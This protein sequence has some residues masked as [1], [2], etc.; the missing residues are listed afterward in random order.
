MNIHE[1]LERDPRTHA[2]ANSGQARITS[3][4]DERAIAE[5]RAELE[6]FVCDGQYGDAIER[7]LKSY[8]TNLTRPKQDAAW[9]SGF[10]GSGK[11]HLL[12]MLGHL[13]VD[14]KFDDGASARSLIHGL[15][16]DIQAHLRELDTMVTRSKQPAFA[17]AGTLPAGSGDFVKMTVLSI[18]LEACGLPQQYAQAKFCF[19]LKEEGYYDSVRN[20]VVDAGKEWLKELNNLYVSSVIAEALIEA[21]PNFAADKREARQTLRAQFPNKPDD[22]TTDE[23]LEMTRNALEIDGELPLTILVLDEVQQYIGNSLDRAVAITEVTEALYTQL[24]SKVMVVASGQSALSGTPLLQKLKDRFRINAPLSDADVES[25]TRKVLLRKKPSCVS[26]IKDILE[27][28][29]GE[30]SKHLDGTRISARSEDSKTIIEDYPLLPSRRRFWEECF[31]AVDA[32]GTHSQLRSQLRILH[33]TLKSIC[34]KNVGMVIPADTLF[35]AISPNLVQTGVL[36][37]E[38]DLKIR[39][40]DD[41]T[42]TGNL[43]KRMCGLVFLITKLPRESGSDVGVRATARSIADLLIEDITT[44]SGTFRKQVETELEQL[45][46]DGTLMKVEDEYR[47]QTT[48]GAEW[49]RAYREKA[50]A[51]RQRESDIS[52]KRE[53]LFGAA[54][55]QIVSEVRL[56]HGESKERRILQLYTGADEPTSKSDNVIVWLRDGWSIAQKDVEAEARQFGQEDPILHVFLPR[57]AADDLTTRIID[58]EATRR[59][60]DQKGIPST[61]EGKEA[62]QSMQSRNAS[63]K[64]MLNELIQE[65]ISTA[66]VFQGGGN[67]VYG[68]SLARKLETAANASLARLFLE[69][70]DGDHKAWGTAL[71]RARDGSDEPLRIVG[72]EKATEDHKVV[73][74]VKSEVGNGAKG[75]DVRGTLQSSP[76]G[77]PRDAIDTALIILHRREIISAHLNGQPVEQGHLDQNKISKTIFKLEVDEPLAATEKLEIRSLFH[78]AGVPVKS[79]EEKSKA[80]EYLSKLRTLAEKAGGE[81]PLP[82]CPST[83]NIDDIAKLHGNEQLKAILNAK[84]ELNASRESWLEISKRIGKRLPRWEQLEQMLPYAEKLPV[85]K[86]ISPEIQA[87]ISNRT[88]LDDTDYVTHLLTKVANALRSALTDKAKKYESAFKIAVKS[89]GDDSI[90]QQID[91]EEKQTILEQVALTRLSPPVT[92]TNENILQELNRSSLNARSSEIVAISARATTALEKAARSINPEAVTVSIRTATLKDEAAVNAWIEEHKKILLAAVAKG[93]VIIG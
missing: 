8:L 7:I 79:G 62:R 34:D 83:T 6:T 59:V 65:I 84:D 85:H 76:Y 28:N 38:I 47:M 18:I 52:V 74:R 82:A 75:K 32:A 53:Q 4:K 23:F 45:A 77:W 56:L 39:Q 54:V 57:K 78:N 19:W 42:E 50:G 9:V 21:D 64:Q 44:D 46:T 35:N 86:N 93:P 33:D 27:K 29:S 1:I 15:P 20:A 43:Q 24:D 87:I 58:L 10:F 80:A 37:N 17:A 73:R 81:A 16:E 91:M 90:W 48:E 61:N 92:K 63:A 68:E 72:W 66:R 12:K 69:F 41:G 71:K 31:R 11:S 25:V 22:I 88:L 26:V 2:L 13:W 3:D 14:T 67:E 60:I 55:Q 30:I 36:L 5:L 40:L 49:D 51:L 70:S 89:L